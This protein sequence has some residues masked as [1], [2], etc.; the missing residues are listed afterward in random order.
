MLYDRPLDSW[1]WGQ[2][3]LVI[4]DNR[5]VLHSFSP[6][7]SHDQRIFT[8][9]EVGKEKPTYEPNR[10][11]IV[12]EDFGD[13]WRKEGV[14][15]DITVG[16]NPDHIPLVFTKGIYA[17]PE[18]ADLFQKVTLFLNSIL[19]YCLLICSLQLSKS[20]IH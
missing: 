11:I 3:D 15:K 20:N 18:Y 16:P 7:W 8:R 14:E 1:E 4:W 2:G 6:G 10:K 17:L 5:A 9:C 12:N 19:L 13:T